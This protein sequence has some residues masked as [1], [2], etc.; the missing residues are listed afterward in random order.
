[1]SSS[2]NKDDARNAEKIFKA[3]D[4]KDEKYKESRKTTSI[5]KDVRAEG[6]LEG[7]YAEATK[8]DIVDF[9]TKNVKELPAPWVERIDRRQQ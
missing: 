9:L 7:D 5:A 6:F 2:V 4:L 1:M 8:K 3:V